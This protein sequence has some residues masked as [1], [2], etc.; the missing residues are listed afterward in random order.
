MYFVRVFLLFPF[1]QPPSVTSHLLSLPYFAGS[2]AKL[3]MGGMLS[4]HRDQYLK[5]PQIQWHSSK[6]Q[7]S[8]EQHIIL[9]AIGV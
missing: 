7:K 2:L 1:S 9:E 4:G 6:P 8:Q 3:L 5:Y